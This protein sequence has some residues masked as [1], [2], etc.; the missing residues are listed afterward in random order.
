MTLLAGDE[1][2]SVVEDWII[3]ETRDFNDCKP[4]HRE[5]LYTLAGILCQHVHIWSLP[6]W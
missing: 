5:I 6:N 3:N 4:S 1:M 2:F